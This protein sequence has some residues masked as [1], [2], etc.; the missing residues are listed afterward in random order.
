MPQENTL[1]KATEK[2]RLLGKPRSP[3]KKSIPTV[4]STFTEKQKVFLYCSSY[5]KKISLL[6]SENGEDFHVKKGSFPLEHCHLVQLD[7]I[8]KGR[9]ALINQNID[10]LAI[11]LSKDLKK[12][13]QPFKVG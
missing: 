13:G 4:I 8:D 5:D 9:F 6:E 1:S 10:G 12:W 7:N 2:K 3:R 11:S